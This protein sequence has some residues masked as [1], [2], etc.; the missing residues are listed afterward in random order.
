MKG[1]RMD[2][3]IWIGCL[4]SYNSGTLFG[5]WFPA[6]D[7]REGIAEV[8]N[9]SPEHIA[10]EWFIADY[11][12]FPNLGENPSI[13]TVERLAELLAKCHDPEAMLAY[14]SAEGRDYA[15]ER[16]EAFEERYRGRFDSV[17]DYV[18]EMCEEV[19]APALN[20]LPELLRYAIDWKS[21]ARDFECSGDI[22]TIREGGSVL[23]FD[24]H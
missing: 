9:T 17:E 8:L 6:S 11:D 2:S 21:V 22:E 18:S 13:E 10:E 14:V 19:F 4:A 3:R 1:D 12:S 20:A 7:I 15:L 5:K 16:A 23:V 24:T